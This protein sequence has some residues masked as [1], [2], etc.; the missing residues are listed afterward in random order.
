MG[1][2]SVLRARGTDLRADGNLLR[3]VGIHHARLGIGL[4]CCSVTLGEVFAWIL[5]WLLLLKHGLAGAT[6]AVGWAGYLG[7]LLGD[8]GIFLPSALTAPYIQST[9]GRHGARYMSRDR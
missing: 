3:G 4:S 6:L 7:S 5:G 9:V 1:T 2:T 8:L